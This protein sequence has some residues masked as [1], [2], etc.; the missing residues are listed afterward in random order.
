MGFSLHGTPRPDDV[1]KVSA[2]LD[3]VTPD[4]GVTV[5][6]QAT[7]AQPVPEVKQKPQ[8]LGD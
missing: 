5:H 1:K 4:K 6:V 2:H 3:D 7:P 8:E